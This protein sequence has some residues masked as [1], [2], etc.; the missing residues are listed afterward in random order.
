MQTKKRE[1]KTFIQIELVKPR[2][3]CD[4]KNVMKNK[5]KHTSEAKT[6][7]VLF[8][9]RLPKD[10]Y[11]EIQVTSGKTG[12]SQTKMAE[13]AFRPF[14]RQRWLKDVAV[15][16]EDLGLTSP[17]TRNWSQIRSLHR[18]PFPAM[19]VRF[20]QMDRVECGEHRCGAGGMVPCLN[21]IIIQWMQRAA[22]S[23]KASPPANA[24]NVSPSARQALDDLLAARKNGN[25]R[26]VYIK[27]LKGY[28]SR[29][30]KG[31]ENL[32]IADISSKDIQAWL[33]NFPKPIS[34]QT[35][36]NRI[37]TLFSY[38]V[39]QEWIRANPCDKIDRVRVDRGAPVILTVKQSRDL[40]AT[41]PK[42]CKAYLVLGMFAGI[43]P[44]EILRLKWESVN[45][46]AGTVRVDGKTRQRRLVPL[47]PVAVRLLLEI[48]DREGPVAP[49]HSTVRRWKRSARVL[50][51]GKWTAGVL[52][53]TAASYLLALHQDAAK[54]ALRL[55]NSPKILLTHYNEPVSATD[56]AAFWSP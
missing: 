4:A 19:P 11:L 21:R 28:L 36:L 34:R 54:V 29:F 44:D 38:A 41:C 56:C 16:R 40:L 26:D 30:I 23:A 9:A 3:P 46:E 25:R 27:S 7:R 39:R 1:C 55:G 2:K 49:S 6:T 20:M 48:P 33:A 18:A 17:L 53:H 32:P 5:T 45:L 43:R 42:S 15:A 31:R 12:M 52:R 24:P 10:L 35:W 14:L 50:I 13:D 22:E 51:G 47:E 8:N 37:S